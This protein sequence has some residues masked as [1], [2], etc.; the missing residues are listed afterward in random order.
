MCVLLVNRPYPHP[1]TRTYTHTKKMSSDAIGTA[2]LTALLDRRILIH[3][4]D[5]SILIGT[6]RSFDAFSNLV[7]E[8]TF[9]R[10]VCP[11]RMLYAHEP[12]GT[13]MVRGDNVAILGEFD[14]TKDKDILKEWKAVPVRI[15]EKYIQHAVDPAFLMDTFM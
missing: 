9:Q 11:E 12:L 2:S 4:S 13:Q 7:L 3:L 14:E 8:H 6:L 15:I 1:P 5:N 10:L